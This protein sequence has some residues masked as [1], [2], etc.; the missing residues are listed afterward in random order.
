[1]VNRERDHAAYYSSIPALIN[2]QISYLSK[3]EFKTLSKCHLTSSCFLGVD[4][5]VGR[6][7]DHPMTQPW[8]V[9]GHIAAVDSINME[10]ERAT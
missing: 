2:E 5:E 9:C 1:M 4:G 7:M 3:Q 6:L 8:A 10:Q